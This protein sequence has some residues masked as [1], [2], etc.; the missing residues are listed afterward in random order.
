MKA[1][2][3]FDFGSLNAYLSHLV[4]PFI[5]LRTGIKFVYVRVLLGGTFKATNNVSPAVSMD[6][7]KKLVYGQIETKRFLAKHEITSFVSNPFFPVNTLQIMC[8]AIYAGREGLLGKYVD[9]VYRHMW[10]ES[11]KMDDSKVIIKA[12]KFSGFDVEKFLL[13]I[14]DPSVKQGLIQNTNRSVEMGSFWLTHL[15]CQRRY[16]FRQ[17]QAHRSR[18]SNT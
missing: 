5:E 14:Q 3:Q 1:E 2:F 4:I 17:R 12:L 6:G 8:G 13:G 15:F 10:S 11:K 7:K 16:L 9:E 18:A